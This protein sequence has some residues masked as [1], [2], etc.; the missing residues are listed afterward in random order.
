MT[1]E[2]ALIHFT[3]EYVK[4]ALVK[5]SQEFEK[6][7]KSNEPWLRER[8]IDAMKKVCALV[9]K[10]QEEQ[11]DYKIMYLNFSLLRTS[12]VNQEYTILVSAYNE[13][14]YLDDYATHINISIY[15]I[16]K[17]LDDL[18][19]YLEEK[20]KK[21]VGKIEGFDVDK[22]LLKQAFE[23]YTSLEIFAVKIFENLDDEDWFQAVEKTNQYCIRWGEYRDL[24]HLVYKMDHN[25]KSKE[26]FIKALKEMEEE[27]KK[28]KF[29]F[30]TWKGIEV[31]D[32]SCSL[33]NLMFSNFKNSTFKGVNMLGIVLL[34]S[35]FK[36]SQLHEC[37]FSHSLLEH[38]SFKNSH[39]ENVSF[40]NTILKDADFTYANFENVSFEN[41]D[42]EAAHFLKKDVPF[43]HLSP[44]QLQKIIIEEE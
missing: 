9:K 40:D 42:L 24:T 14:W 4:E 21:Y 28:D 7:F 26:D 2:E 43:I 19:N 30:S 27:D 33:K 44:L 10:K 8:L 39:L 16:F 20:R 15:P 31:E 37:N 18:K 11:K 17:V 38:A 3:N 36:N 32:L 12:V 23:Y 13:N 1:R 6:N 29:V 41:S 34:G 25:D 5:N 22:I 35:N